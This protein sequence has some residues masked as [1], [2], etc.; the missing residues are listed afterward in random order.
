MLPVEHVVIV[1]IVIDG[2]ALNWRFRPEVT[3]V[4]ILAGAYIDIGKAGSRLAK[5]GRHADSIFA[6]PAGSEEAR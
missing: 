2:E 4:P 1:E 5:A 6:V 3:H